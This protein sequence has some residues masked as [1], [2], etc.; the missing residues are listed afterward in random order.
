MSFSPN[1]IDM[2]NAPLPADKVSERKQAGQTLSFIEGWHAIAEANRI[3]GHDGWDSETALSRLGE[4]EQVDGKWRVRFMA[5][6]T[7]RVRT[8]DEN[9]V[10]QGV[11]YGSGI[12]RDLGDAYEG[13]IKEAETDGRKR[14]LM[15]F[16]WPFGLAL[17]DKSR[18][19]VAA[20]PKPA[21]KPS[22]T[23]EQDK[24]AITAAAS[25]DELKAIWTE[26]FQCSR[27]RDTEEGQQELW[28]LKE[29]RKEELSA[30]P[31]RELSVLEAG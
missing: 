23:L 26:V 3:F 2:L 27:E 18:E 8:D 15:T 6:V 17:Y 14:A 21:P 5:Q 22:R 31:K 28:D 25:M 10:R 11:G 16:G 30:P 1:Q 13:A 24:A 12:A 9:I 4:P 7:I 29:A 20:A 19:H